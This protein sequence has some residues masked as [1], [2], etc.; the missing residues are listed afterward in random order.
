MKCAPYEKQS[1]RGKRRWHQAA[2]FLN[3]HPALLKEIY[4][5]V[6]CTGIDA[7]DFIDYV[8]AGKKGFTRAELLE[9]PT[10]MDNWTKE[11][12][13]AKEANSQKWSEESDFC[14]LLN[15]RL[16]QLIRVGDYTIADETKTYCFSKK[17]YITKGKKYRIR[18]LFDERG[19]SFGCRTSTDL[20]KESNHESVHGIK[21][22]W[23][24]GKE[25]WNWNLEYLK[26]WQ[27]QNPGHPQWQKMIEHCTKKAKKIRRGERD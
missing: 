4:L 21:V 26:L 11:Q 17:Q 5:D 12:L 9:H 18:E 7:G 3:M 8:L 20:P 2:S 25:I 6:W 22:L 10:K 19:S 1:I 27:E 14:D 23:R 13:D 15:Y 24:N 16:K